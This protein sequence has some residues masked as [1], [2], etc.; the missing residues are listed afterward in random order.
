MYGR[1]KTE[2]IR[3]IRTRQVVGAHTLMPALGRQ[4]QAFLCELEASLVC[5]E[6]SRIGSKTYTKNCCLEKPKKKHNQKKYIYT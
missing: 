4:R 2:G 3:I 1:E 5:I 6:S